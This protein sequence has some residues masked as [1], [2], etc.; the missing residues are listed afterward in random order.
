M[1]NCTVRMIETILASVGERIVLTSYERA[2]QLNRT[3]MKSQHS[4][5]AYPLLITPPYQVTQRMQFNF[6]FLPE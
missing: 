1:S 3:T 4:G 5:S 2:I 6:V